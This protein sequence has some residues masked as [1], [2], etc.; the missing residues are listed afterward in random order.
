MI[1]FS[2][3]DADWLASA[4]IAQRVTLWSIGAWNTGGGTKVILDVF[5]LDGL[6]GLFSSL[7]GFVLVLELSV[8]LLWNCD[9]TLNLIRILFDG[10][11]LLLALSGTA[12][13]GDLSLVSAALLV[14]DNHVLGTDGGGWT[15]SGGSEGTNTSTSLEISALTLEAAWL[16]HNDFAI[17]VLEVL[18]LWDLV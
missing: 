5:S 17:V 2:V 16:G 11:L 9:L 14:W 6:S 12:W 13:L 8:F 18:E 1:S 7:L 10:G 3:A 4:S 15:G